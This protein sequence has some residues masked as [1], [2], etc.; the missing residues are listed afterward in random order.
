MLQR[1]RVLLVAASTKIAK[2]NS[3]KEIRQNFR[4]NH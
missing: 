3:V 4:G 1:V 2:R